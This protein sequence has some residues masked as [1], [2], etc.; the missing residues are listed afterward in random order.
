MWQ[1]HSQ[2]LLQT[3]SLYQ[4]PVRLDKPLCALTVRHMAIPTEGSIATVPIVPIHARLGANVRMSKAA[5]VGCN[6]R[7]LLRR[8][9]L[10]LLL[11][12]RQLLGSGGRFEPCTHL[13]PDPSSKRSTGS[14]FPLLCLGRC[15]ECADADMSWNS[16]VI[17]RQPQPKATWEASEQ[18]QVYVCT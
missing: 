18:L 2:E 4:L 12:S 3:H 7:G 8:I 11:P 5:K 1:N 17:S 10:L 14:P 16:Q 15:K 9:I 13:E 6:F